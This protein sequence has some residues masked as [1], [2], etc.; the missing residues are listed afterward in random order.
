MGDSV[1]NMEDGGLRQDSRLQ[2]QSED[3]MEDGEV[4]EVSQAQHPVIAGPDRVQPNLPSNVD[5]PKKNL[6]LFC[7]STLGQCT[8]GS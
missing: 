1:S 8:T 3:E 4:R 5:D 6:G 7:P 2:N